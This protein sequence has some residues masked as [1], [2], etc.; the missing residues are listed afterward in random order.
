[1]QQNVGESVY[2]H[3]YL[4]S[5]HHLLLIPKQQI[6]QKLL[7]EREP[8]H[9]EG[10]CTAQHIVKHTCNLCRRCLTRSTG[11]QDM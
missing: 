10:Y 2:L 4:P 3:S 1:M 5:L 6:T 8:W 7:E 9:V 11:F